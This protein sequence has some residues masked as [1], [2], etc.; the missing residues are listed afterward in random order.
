MRTVAAALILLTALAAQP[1]AEWQSTFPVDKKNL[2]IRGSNAYFPLTPGYR[3]AFVHGPE[4]DVLT[5][6][7]ETKVIDGVECRIIEDRETKNGQL[8]EITRDYYA[9]D[10][11]TNDVYYMGEEVDVYKDGKVTSHEGT[12]LSG[13]KGAKF[14][15]FLPANP[16]V[17]RRFYQEQAPGV[18]MD[19]IEIVS[20]TEKVD[21]PAGRFENCV[22]TLETTPLE[23]NVRD[24]KWFARGIGI[25]KDGV[26]V[27]ERPPLRQ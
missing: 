10:A 3:L 23:K 7:T 26:L 11:A 14:G 15:L 27:L 24:Y 5:V 8:T 21:T 4:T 17:G 18:G 2:G 6:L 19:R 16:A 1:A 20:V 9:L 22:K 13:V 12:W 25:V